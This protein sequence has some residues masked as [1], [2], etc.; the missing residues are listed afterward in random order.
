MSSHLCFSIAYL[1]GRFHGRK[2]GRTPEWPPSPLR[3]FQAL[4]A[5]VMRN[6]NGNEFLPAFRWLEA[7]PPPVVV[8]PAARA[9]QPLCLSVPNNAM[10]IVGR[11]LARGNTSGKG[12]ANPSTHRAMK[13]VRPLVLDG[14]A[15]VHF[16]WPL[17]KDAPDAVLGH[18]EQLTIAARRIVALGWGI[19]L[20]AGR[21]NVLTEA[22]LTELAGERWTASTSGGGSELRTPV[23]GTLDAL[24]SRHQQFLQRVG[25]HGMVPTSPLSPSA[26][27]MLT[28]RRAF[29]P[30]PRSVA[31]FQLLDL[32]AERMRPFDLRQPCVVAGMMRHVAADAAERSAWTKDKIVRFVLG[33]GEREGGKPVPVGPERFAFLP[34]PSLE[35]RGQGKA[36][37]VGS[38][39]RVLVTS[40]DT[41]AEAEVS[42]VR[43]AL[44][45]RDL[46]DKEKQPQALLTL[47]AASDSVVRDY[48]RE[49]A[50]WTTVSPVI[51]PGWDDRAPDKAESLLRKAIVQ[52]GYPEYLA[53]HANV[54]FRPVGFLPGVEHARRYRVPS[55]LEHYPRY[56]VRITWRDASGQPVEMPGPVCLGG[57]R[58]GGTGLFVAVR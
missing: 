6:G 9:G 32:E 11:A 1:D 10:D 45:G 34:L 12:D 38:I 28:Y 19:D 23:P 40:F 55:H 37:V 39:R 21:A 54:E 56:H 24:L 27:A 46:I 58:F 26:Y 53:Q 43:R 31:A 18:V 20:V 49:S 17:P 42:W 7:Q 29:D 4:L 16:A 14:E 52:A 5:S 48:V 35:G 15:T 33:H 2:E 36:R 44:N 51:L 47:I 57:G 8:A 25:E 41:N 30:A 50:T 3:L 13:N 22:A